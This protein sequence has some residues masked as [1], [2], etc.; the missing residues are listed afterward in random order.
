[1]R[2]YKLHLAFLF[3][4]ALAFFHVSQAQNSQEDYLT[5]H[6]SARSEVGVGSMTWD[7]TVATYAQNYA[8]QRA[9]DCNLVHSGGSYGENLAWSSGDMS[10]TDAVNMW[11]AEKTYYDYNSNSCAEGQQCGHY[12]QVVWRNSVRL[13]C[14]RVQCSSG[15]GTFII[16]NYDPPGNYVGVAEA[17]VFDVKNYD[18]KADGKTEI[19]K[20]VISAW[21]DACASVQPSTVLISEGTYLL[22]PVVL[23]RP[24]KTSSIEFQ[25]QG[26]VKAPPDPAAFKTDGWIVFQY[27]NGLTVLGGGTIDGQGQKAWTINNCAA[28]ANCRMLPV[29]RFF[30][31]PRAA[32]LILIIW[33]NIHQ[34][35][36][37]TMVLSLTHSAMSLR[38]NFM[39][40]TMI[41]DITSLNSKNF[42]IN[43]FQ[44]YDL[45]L[46]N[47]Y[48]IAPG[49]SA[50][51]DDIH[52]GD[53]ARIHVT[54]ISIAT[55]D[56]CSSIGPAGNLQPKLH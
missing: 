19:R 46:K 35:N 6:N 23:K 3:F 36:G 17:T 25:V 27:I 20:A 44:C 16:C 51:T 54:D 45:T 42:H 10:A 29:I 33:S 34:L 9:E 52:M 1:M 39:N 26:L 40:N 2:S 38:F 21:N 47:L 8:N 13:G 55:G 14:A 37:P 4:I 22:G 31:Y 7:D 28:N 49:D 12:T 5:T 50:N 30:C 18:A 53:S 41:R 48:I 11:V 32:A 56:D 15:S 24:C 43:I